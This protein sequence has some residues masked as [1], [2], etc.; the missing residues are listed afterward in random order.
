MWNEE[1]QQE[2]WKAMELIQQLEREQAEHE[3]D[4]VIQLAD[5][6]DEIDIH[7]IFTFGEWEGVATIL[8]DNREAVIKL[9]E[10]IK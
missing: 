9:L 2:L 10:D 7:S 3:E 1:K 8:I 4:C 5:A 6:L